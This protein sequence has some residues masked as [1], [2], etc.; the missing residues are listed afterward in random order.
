M[1]VTKGNDKELQ[2]GIRKLVRIAKRVYPKLAYEVKI[3]A[4]ED[5]DAFLVLY[6]PPKYEDKIQHALTRTKSLP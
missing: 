1:P 6:C 5:Q 3:P 2:N 4:Y